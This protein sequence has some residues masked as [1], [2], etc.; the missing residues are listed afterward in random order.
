MLTARPPAMRHEDPRQGVPDE[1]AKHH[2][3]N[4][5]GP[6]PVAE[7]YAE[8][9]DSPSPETARTT[10]QVGPVGRC[11][12]GLRPRAGWKLHL[13]EG[14]PELRQQRALPRQE[15]CAGQQRPLWP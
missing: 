2:K 1:P 13:A 11:S 9:W 10:A 7:L 5:L 4:I 12:A 8:G 3:L 14:L 15:L 6:G